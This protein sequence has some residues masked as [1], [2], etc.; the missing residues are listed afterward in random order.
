MEETTNAVLIVPKENSMTERDEVLSASTS[1]LYHLPND[2][3]SLTSLN[4]IRSELIASS[5]TSP[6]VTST[7]CLD[8]SKLHWRMPRSDSF[9]ALPKRKVSFPIR[10]SGCVVDNSDYDHPRAYTTISITTAID[11]HN[12]RS[13]F[14]EPNNKQQTEQLLERFR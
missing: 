12:Y 4:S 11:L 7:S 6:P 2:K 8:V 3:L 10:D 9:P 13:P 1:K 5:S 14:I